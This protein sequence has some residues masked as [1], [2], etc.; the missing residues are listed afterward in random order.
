MKDRQDFSRLSTTHQ[1]GDCVW[2][3]GTHL[4]MQRPKAKLDAKQFGPFIISAKLGPVT[5]Q[6]DIP[7]TWK[8]ARIHPVF[9]A[10]LLMPYIEAPEHGPN[11]LQPPPIVTQEGDKDGSAYEVKKVLDARPTRN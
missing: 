7:L 6:L 9:H 4:C 8:N 11:H 3:K 5:Y 1:V 10:S 2:L